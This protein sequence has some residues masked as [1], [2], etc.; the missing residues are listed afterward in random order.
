M[1]S[2]TINNDLA[3]QLEREIIIDCKPKYT[4]LN[5]TAEYNYRDGSLTAGG[6][7]ILHSSGFTCGVYVGIRDYPNLGTFENALAN[8]P[9]S[10]VARLPTVSK[11][12]LHLKNRFLDESYDV[13][14][15]FVNLMPK[16]VEY[17]VT[18]PHRDMDEAN[19]ITFLYYVIDSDGDTFLFDEANDTI[20]SRH[21]PRKGTGL[22]YMSSVIHS[23]SI[24]MQHEI[25]SAINI[26]YCKD[27][28]KSY[29]KRNPQRTK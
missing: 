14:R 11:F 8:I 2:F 29:D 7:K 25:R 28:F 23:A 18:T 21:T 6:L 12:V 19:A 17:G 16:G 22:T 20:I 3:N 13:A 26:V 27:Y 9:S 15:V 24:P 10:K 1:K 5:K 4:F